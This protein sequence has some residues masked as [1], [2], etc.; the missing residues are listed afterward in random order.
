MDDFPGAKYGSNLSRL[1]DLYF[2]PD[3]FLMLWNL[4][5]RSWHKKDL[6]LWSYATIINVAD[7]LVGRNLRLGE[8]PIHYSYR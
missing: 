2:A 7:R 4:F 6:R 3:C 5:K 8:L 1:F